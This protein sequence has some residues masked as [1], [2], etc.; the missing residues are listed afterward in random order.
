[1]TDTDDQND[2]TT[3]TDNDDN[4]V[5]QQTMSREEL[6]GRLAKLAKK[7]GKS[8]AEELQNMT[9]QDLRSRVTRCQMN[10]LETK[11]AMERDEVL[12]EMKDK[13]KDLAGPYRDALSNQKRI[14]E[15]A[16]L[17]LQYE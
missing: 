5:E 15:Y 9:N 6:D 12:S 1:M 7:I 14:A 2:Q 10:I 11:L 3:N 16:A 13:V 17:R 8:M 4:L